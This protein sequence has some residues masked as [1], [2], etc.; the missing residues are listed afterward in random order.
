[1]KGQWRRVA[2]VRVTATNDTRIAVETDGRA[3]RVRHIPGGLPRHVLGVTTSM[4]AFVTVRI[5]KP[6]KARP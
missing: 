2:L 4:P 6:R 5:T 3:F 1:M